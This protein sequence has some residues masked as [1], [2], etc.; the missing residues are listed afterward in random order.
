MKRDDSKMF[1]ENVQGGLAC[2]IRVIGMCVPASGGQAADLDEAKIACER[3]LLKL[4][5]YCKKRDEMK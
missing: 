1:A 5:A 2:A 3:A 4:Q